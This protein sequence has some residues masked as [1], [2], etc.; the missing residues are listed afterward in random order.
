MV[1][2]SS[3]SS[4][5]YVCERLAPD[6]LSSALSAPAPPSSSASACSAESSTAGSA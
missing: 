4:V 6:A 1:S 2:S 3:L 5:A